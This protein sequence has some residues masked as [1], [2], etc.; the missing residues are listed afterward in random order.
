MKRSLRRLAP[1]T[2]AVQIVLAS[3]SGV[4]PLPEPVSNNAVA[5][6]KLHGQFQLFSLM[7]IGP[8]KTWNAVTNAGYEVDA[9]SAKVRTIHSVPGT[10]GRIGAM[11]VGATGRLFLF[12]GYVLFQGG[13]MAVPDGN[14]YEPSKDRW[15]RLP[16]IPIA[17]GDAVIGVY[18]ERY[19]YLVGG[20]TN[21]RIISDVQLYDL[22]KAT[23]SKA[24]PMPGPPVFGH[25]GGI[26]GDIIIYVDG[27]R[28]NDA[29][30][31]PRFVASD[32][33]WAGRIDHHNPG[34]IEWSKL[35]NHPGNAR[36]RIAAGAS[37]KDGAVYFAG[38]SDSPH[39]YNGTGYDGKPAEPA[40]FTFAFNLR[41]G[42]WEMLSENTPD[43]TMDHRGLLVTPEGLVVIGGMEKGQQVTGRIAVLP[44]TR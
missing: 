18:R 26:A 36:F 17:V 9:G 20:R 39:D 19:I 42:K 25:A 24:T 44:K 14:F 37:E 23:W 16:D 29:G 15:V 8:K 43:P 27:A 5:I 12:G 28:T 4:E 2:L 35:P 40:P 13:G 31:G 41:S 1:L 21:G 3:P 22:E 32:E 33:C 7:G 11:A 6:L 38:G 10:A 30:Q 34:R